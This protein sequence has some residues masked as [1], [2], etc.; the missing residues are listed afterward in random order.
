MY[1]FSYENLSLSPIQRMNTKKN[2]LR[3]KKNPTSGGA[4]GRGIT[5]GRGMI[6]QENIHPC[7]TYPFLDALDDDGRIFPGQP[8]EECRNSH[9]A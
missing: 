2:W 3:G 8:A 4:G 7:V 5:R 6:F 1:L 9:S